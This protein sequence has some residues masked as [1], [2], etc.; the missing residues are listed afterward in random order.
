M[1]KIKISNTLRHLRLAEIMFE[2]LTPSVDGDVA[3][4][5]PSPL[6]ADGSQ[7]EH[8]ISGGQLGPVV[9]FGFSSFC[10]KKKKKC[11]FDPTVPLLGIYPKEITRDTSK[12]G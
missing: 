9:V 2:M 12:G 4:K 3:G 10:K 6:G 5:A 8:R 7:N 1:V 11:S